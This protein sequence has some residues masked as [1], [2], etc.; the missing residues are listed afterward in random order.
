MTGVIGLGLERATYLFQTHYI[1]MPDWLVFSIIASIL[2][3]VGAN[4]LLW[5]FPRIGRTAEERFLQQMDDHV[6]GRRRTRF[7]FP[8]KT[9]LLLSVIG[10]IALNLF[11]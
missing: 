2:V 7:I 5:I 9:M 3:T 1:P 6:S 8:W 11:L 10:T 4:A